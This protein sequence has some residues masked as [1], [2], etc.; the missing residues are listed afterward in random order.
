[1]PILLAPFVALIL[2]AVHGFA[3]MASQGA[4]AG[5]RGWWQ[6]NGPRARLA[7]FGLLTFLPIHAFFLMRYGDWSYAYL[8]PSSRVPSALELLLLVFVTGLLLVGHELL[9]RARATQRGPLLRGICGAGLGVMLLL[10][11][12]L[13]RRWGTL[14]TY[15]QY[16][17]AFGLRP[18]FP[19]GFGIVVLSA[20]TFAGVAFHWLLRETRF[21]RGR[22]VDR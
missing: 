4:D 20:W 8:G 2:G 17:G 7:L 21:N 13:G 11:V 16:K 12:V 14:G 18:A 3:T 15:A 6:G 1:V 5:P 10:V 22:T 19:S 9:V